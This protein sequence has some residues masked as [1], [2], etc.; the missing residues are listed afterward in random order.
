MFRSLPAPA[1]RQRGA[2]LILLLVMLV[3][4]TLL[5]LS[6]VRTT[7]MGEKMAGNARDRNKAFQ[8]AEAAVQSCLSMVNAGTYPGMVLTPVAP[9]ATPPTPHWEVD[10]NWNEGAGASYEVV[11]ADA[12]L[13]RNP[14]CMVEV[15]GAGTGSYRVTGR[16]LGG[17]TESLVMLQATYSKE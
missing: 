16:A 12:G 5:T 7:T 13:S 10:A 3:V 15:L 4:I 17:S 14:R 6:T 9:T 2:T 1:A 11:L 8:A